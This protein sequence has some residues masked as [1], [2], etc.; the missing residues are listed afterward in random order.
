M[1]EYEK[2][3]RLDYLWKKTRKY[4]KKLRFIARSQMMSE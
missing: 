3:E 1:D 4:V 2:R